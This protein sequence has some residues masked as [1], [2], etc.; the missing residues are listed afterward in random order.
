MTMF[1]KET[2]A[3]SIRVLRH[4][5]TDTPYY[6][7]FSGGKD[8]VVLHEIARRAAVAVEW[9]YHVT[10]IDPPDLTRFILRQYPHVIWDRPAIPFFEHLY[11]VGFPTRQ[12]RKCCVAY[13][14]SHN[15]APGQTMILVVRAAESARRA[16]AWSIT[17]NARGFPVIAPILEWTDD[18]VW[19]FIR[20]NNLPYCSLYDEGFKRLGCVG[21]PMA[22]KDRIRMLKRY[23][24]IELGYRA[25]FRRWWNRRASKDPNWS[26]L[27]R[28]P[29]SDALFDW[30]IGNEALPTTDEE[31]T[32][33]NA[34][35]PEAWT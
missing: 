19:T 27:Q 17:S 2:I 9:H 11:R 6:G 28:F 3:K 34:L 29:D 22:G 5:A 18:E 1:I 21:C 32:C 14:E 25:A 4:F 12:F 30:W 8:S 23:P 24:G 16:K 7:G 26:Y 33:D 10:T 20:D 31:G 13:K 15:P 35:P